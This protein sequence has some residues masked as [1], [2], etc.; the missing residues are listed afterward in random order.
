ME[1]EELSRWIK[2]LKKQP[3]LPA[4]AGVALAIG[5]AGLHRL[6]PHRAPMLLVDGLEALDLENR[7]IRGHLTLRA[8]DPVFVG[9]F[10]GEPV[11]PGVLQVEAMGQ[12]ALCL[13]HFVTRNTTELQA[14]AAP[15]PVRA[16]AIHYAQYLQPLF[17]GD[18]VELQAALLE[19]DGM[20]ATCAGQIMKGGVVA[21]LSV[22]EV[23]FVE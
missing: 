17:P 20:T 11:Y 1:P 15:V 5:E 4:G 21:A 22:Q 3:L 10:P 16:L 8:E 18:R 14:D 7:T 12:L 13:A 9:H 19:E 23:Y 6:L 2:R